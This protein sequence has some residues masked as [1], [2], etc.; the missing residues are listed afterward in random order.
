M[1]TNARDK[2][3]AE[4]VS[5]SVVSEHLRT[6]EF[7]LGNLTKAY[8]VITDRSKRITVTTWLRG[9][10][11][12][13]QRAAALS[14]MQGQSGSLPYSNQLPAVLDYLQRV[15]SEEPYNQLIPAERYPDC[16]LLGAEIK[17]KSDTNSIDDE[18]ASSSL[19]KHGKDDAVYIDVWE[20]ASNL[21]DSEDYNSESKQ[22]GTKKQQGHLDHLGDLLKS[23]SGLLTKLKE[24]LSTCT[25]R[26]MYS[27]YGMQQWFDEKATEKDKST[28]K[29]GVKDTMNA[30]VDLQKALDLSIANDLLKKKHRP[31]DFDT[32][33]AMCRCGTLDRE[34]LAVSVDKVYY[35][36]FS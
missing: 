2:H 33:L 7:G 17:T 25:G 28:I 9:W 24:D 23:Y 21:D 13:T 20:V 32:L 6:L 4:N 36:C 5:M 15:F 16:H 34:K 14:Y 30:Y 12:K 18:T 35:G 27:K 3:L 1:T 26:F 22:G 10:Q 8:I 19:V 29:K 11:Y 31:K